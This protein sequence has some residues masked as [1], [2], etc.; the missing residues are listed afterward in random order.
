[1][2]EGEVQRLPAVVEILDDLTRAGVAY[3]HWKS[4]EKLATSL[5]GN[6]DL[7]LLVR[8]ADAGALQETFARHGLRRVSDSSLK[9]FPAIEQYFGLD[10]S[11]GKWLHIDVYYQII[12]GSNLLKEFHL[13]VER[14]L[15]E[16]NDTH[17]GVPVPRP[18]AELLVLVCIQLIKRSSLLQLLTREDAR[19]TA[20]TRGEIEAIIERDPE[21]AVEAQKLLS[22]WLPQLPA[23]LWSDCYRA[24]LSGSDTLRLLNL[25]SRLR[26]RLS[27]LRRTGRGTGLWI[28]GAAMANKLLRRRRIKRGSKLLATGGAVVAFIGPEA[29]GKSTLVATLTETLGKHFQV[30]QVHLGKPP[31][32]WLT[33]PFAALF[34]VLRRLL[35]D[36]RASVGPTI[37]TELSD[38]VGGRRDRSESFGW[39]YA[40]RALITAHERRHLARR[41]QRLAANGSL[42]VCDRY[43]SGVVGAMD[44]ARLSPHASSGWRRRAAAIEQRVYRSIPPPSLVIELTVSVDVALERNRVRVKDRKESDQY[45]KYRHKHQAVPVFAASQTIRVDT[46][47]EL[48]PLKQLV[49]HSVWK[50]L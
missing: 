34:P 35:P 19:S 24:L 16:G 39:M 7:D 31:P 18:A 46:S 41:V 11:S 17:L 22:V 48:E 8:R 49:V 45:V 29:T 6:D 42:I 33:W 12:T 38:A 10:S 37:E 14:L 3:K 25:G 13:P 47:G 32:T 4:N 20:V 27:D 40:L 44:S 1:M 23:S 50:A 5:A 21:A 30:E 26:A 36:R 9:P 43:P 15:L 2:L 28:R